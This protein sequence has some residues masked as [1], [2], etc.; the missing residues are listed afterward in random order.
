[1][2]SFENEGIHEVS[3]GNIHSW[4]L[5]APTRMSPQRVTEVAPKLLVSKACSQCATA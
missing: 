4:L 5:L 1:M 3:N 2:E